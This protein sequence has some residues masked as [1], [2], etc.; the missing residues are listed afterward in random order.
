MA[1]ITKA[2]TIHF[3]VNGE[4]DFLFGLSDDNLI[5]YAG[6]EIVFAITAESVNDFARQFNLEVGPIPAGMA[7]NIGNPGPYTVAPGFPIGIQV[8]I[9]LAKD[10]VPGNY[11]ITFTA[12]SLW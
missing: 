7:V 3:V 10:V 5:G 9:V 4:Q 11:E 1:I 8:I 12:T 2:A 6:D